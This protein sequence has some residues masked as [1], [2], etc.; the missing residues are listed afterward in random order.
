MYRTKVK[1]LWLA[2][3]ILKRL[4]YAPRKII[5]R[6]ELLTLI[7]QIRPIN[8]GFELIRMGGMG[9]GS[10]LLPN[11]LEGISALISP[12][13]GVSRRFEDELYNQFKINSILVDPFVAP[14]HLNEG[15]K[16]IRTL[17]AST[18]N[19]SSISLEDLI[20]ISPP[21]DLM[22]QMD[23]ESGEYEA[24]FATNDLNL[25]RF[26]II[27]VEF[28][29]IDHWLDKV[30]FELF[31]KPLFERILS[32]FD[33]VHIHPNTSTGY[34]KIGDIKFPRFAEFTFHRKDRFRTLGSDRPIPHE[35]DTLTS[36]LDKN[37]RWFFSR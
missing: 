31:I 33:V 29:R 25:L 17:V 22:L 4:R 10:Y 7:N 14:S 24:L 6:S 19:S 11:D 26:R 1:V 12:G 9:D 32:N 27:I 15:D 18:T 13:I 2:S 28:H 34:F 23:I 35:L 3:T 30:Q 20:R 21:G 37:T 8:N 5:S 16:Y 36:S